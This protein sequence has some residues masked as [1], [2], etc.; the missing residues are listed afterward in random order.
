MRIIISVTNRGGGTCRKRKADKP[1]CP[2]WSHCTRATAT[3][4]SVYV[5]SFHLGRPASIGIN[6][7]IVGDLYNELLLLLIV[8][9]FKYLFFQI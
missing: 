7:S 4:V 3:N 2:Q 6:T 9:Y 5:I 1:R 8:I